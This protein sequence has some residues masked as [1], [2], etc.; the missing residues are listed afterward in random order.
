M[1]KPIIDSERR[2]VC[3]RFLQFFKFFFFF[4]DHLLEE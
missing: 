4:Y 3:I 2:T 1:S